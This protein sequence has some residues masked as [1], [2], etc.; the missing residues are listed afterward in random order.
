MTTRE[1]TLLRVHI[2]ATRTDSS[3]LEPG[4]RTNDSPISVARKR[5]LSPA[6]LGYPAIYLRKQLTVDG[7]LIRWISDR[8]AAL[9]LMRFNAPVITCCSRAPCHTG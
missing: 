5:S 6:S 7:F 9:N 8:L 2:K 1:V 3:R 4:H